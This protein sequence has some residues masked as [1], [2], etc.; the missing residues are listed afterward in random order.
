MFQEDPNEDVRPDFTTEEH[1]PARQQL[2]NDGLT[3]EQAAC[4]LV[5]L[6]NITNN[7]TKDCWALKQQRLRA[8]CLHEDKDAEQCLQ[9]LRDK[10][11]AARLEERKKNKNKYE[12]LRH[13]KL[14]AGEFCEMHYF[15]NK[16]LDDAKTAVLVADPDALVM[17]PSA[18][19]IHTCV[20][21]AAVKDPKASAIVRD[22]NLTWEEFNEAA[23]HMI[24]MMKVYDWPEDR[25]DMHIQFWLALQSHHWH[26]ANDHLKQCALLLYQ[27]QQQ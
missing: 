17:L 20:L 14:K 21:A 13:N 23:P 7:T 5:S 25:V 24:N 27:L 9:L 12:P 22:E 18:N 8:I 3:E 11:D 4:S 2:I 1:E 10:E 26:H 15:T 19:G 16:G 6:W